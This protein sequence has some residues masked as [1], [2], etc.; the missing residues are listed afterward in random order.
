M[1][2]CNEALSKCDI[3]KVKALINSE[4]PGV[5]FQKSLECIMLLIGDD[6]SGKD[7]SEDTHKYFVNKLKGLE[8]D[9]IKQMI[10]V[11]HLKQVSDSAHD[12]I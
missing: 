5:N 2:M 1:L 7:A 3:D 6:Q 11:N 4:K 8:V 12:K 10:S 9:W